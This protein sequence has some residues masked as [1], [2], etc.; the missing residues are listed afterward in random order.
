M[1][2][3]EE[4]FIIWVLYGWMVW[5]ETFEKYADG[6]FNGFRM[7][8]LLSKFRIDYSALTVIPDITKRADKATKAFFE[9]LIKG[10]K[11]DPEESGE[12]SEYVLM[13]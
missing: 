7:A 5:L 9:G 4:V 8:S 2:P 11:G 3:A 12:W 13:K 6:N 1:L 10:F